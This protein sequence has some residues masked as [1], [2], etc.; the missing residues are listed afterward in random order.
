MCCRCQSLSHIVSVTALYK[1][2]TDITFTVF[3]TLQVA[4][5]SSQVPVLNGWRQALWNS[6]PGQRDIRLW[7]RSFYTQVS[8][9]VAWVSEWIMMMIALILIALHPLMTTTTVWSCVGPR[10]RW[11]PNRCPASFELCEKVLQIHWPIVKWSMSRGRWVKARKTWM[12]VPCS[13]SFF[14][15]SLAHFQP[16]ALVKSAKSYKFP[17]WD[18]WPASSAVS[19]RLGPGLP[20]PV[21][22]SLLNRKK[23][24]S[25]GNPA[26]QH[27]KT[28]L[29]GHS[30]DQTGS[31]LSHV[32]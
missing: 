17:V 23:A 5:E 15:H 8:I 16:L 21:S 19:P 10:T 1:V 25:F 13:G 11:G 28:G 9:E 30:G 27:W 18:D 29:D 26:E 14:P 31:L 6:R 24:P 22:W 12:A 4:A 32:L 3:Q 7:A 2:D 20:W